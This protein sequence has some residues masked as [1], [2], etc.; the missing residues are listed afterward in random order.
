MRRPLSNIEL[1]DLE[2]LKAPSEATKFGDKLR[3]LRVHHGLTLAFMSQL[4]GYQT[5]S[6]I[7]EIES[8][9]KLPTIGLVLKVS[10][11][12]TVTTDELLKDEI[13]V[14]LH[15]SKLSIKPSTKG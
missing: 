2:M 10:R 11:L 8:G 7:S 15:K 14:D 3:Q 9:H 13:T 4:F 1:L 5:H 6:Y 12:F